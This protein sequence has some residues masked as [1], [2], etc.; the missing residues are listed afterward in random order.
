[1]R[2]RRPAHALLRK[3]EGWAQAVM[4]TGTEDE[5][6]DSNRYSLFP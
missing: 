1:L 4:T 5:G 2:S 3:I 6:Q